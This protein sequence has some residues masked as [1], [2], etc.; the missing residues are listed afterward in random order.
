MFKK[1]LLINLT[2]FFF[3][4]IVYSNNIS[5]IEIN[6]NKRLT[7][8]SIVVF[9]KIDIEKNID[10]QE[11]NKILKRLYSTDFFKNINIQTKDQ[12]LKIDVVENPIIQSVTLEGIKSK[13]FTKSIIDTLNLRDKSSFV[14]NTVKI[15]EDIIINSLRGRGYFFSKVESK[16]I[17]LDNDI[18]NLIYKVEMGKKA[19]IN[20]IKFIGDKKIK[21]RKLKNVIVS[22]EAKFWKFISS[23]QYLNLAMVNLDERLLLNYFKNKGFFNVVVESSFAQLV[24]DNYFDLVYKIDAGNKFYY[25]DIVLNLPLDYDK[26]NFSKMLNLFKDLKGKRFSLNS[27]EKILKE[28]DQ[29]SILEQYQF[30]NASVEENII[31]ENQINLIFNIAE[32]EKKYVERINIY[33]NNVTVETVIRNNLKVDEGDPYNELLNKKSINKLKSLNY[34]KTVKSEIFDGKK[35]DTKVINII[36]EEKPT[37]EISAGA[38]IG[39]SGGTLAFSVKENNYLGKGINFETSLQLSEEKVQGVFAVKNPNFNGTNKSLNTRIESSE[40]DR[41]KNFGYKSTK[42]GFIVGTT[43]EQYQDTFLTGSVS[44]FYENLTT[45]TSASSSLQRQMELTF[46]IS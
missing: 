26:N 8:D 3:S 46:G 31:S 32:T 4:N 42:T 7:K 23:K 12:I 34:F 1:I 30:I 44:S 11:I 37:G 29:I 38:G 35:E 22:E 9:G 14:L 16:I 6:G 40:T 19:K 21:D 10:K 15:D 17:K 2:I 36:V 24:N 33:G 20:K 27:T 43:Y 13:K 39:T 25:N 45:D 5:K 41:L 28:I 18:I